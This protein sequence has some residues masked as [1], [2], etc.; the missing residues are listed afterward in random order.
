M[1]EVVLN[2]NGVAYGGWQALRVHRGLEE[3]SGAFEIVATELWP[4]QRDPREIR[5]GDRC[6]L[7][8]DG[9]TVITGFVD[10]VRPSYGDGRHEVLIRGRDA[11]GDLV[12]CSAVHKSGEWRNATL[13]QIAR[14][15]VAPFGLA[16]KVQT[17]VGAP[18]KQWAIQ[19]GESVFENLERAARHRGVLLLSDGQGALVIA[20][21]S[22]QRVGT[23]LERG[24]NI[25]SA[26][27]ENNQADRFSRYIVKGQRAG[28]DQDSGEVVA[29]QK[30]EAR[31]PGVGRYRPLVLVLEDQGD[32][33]TLQQRADFEAN[34]RAARAL[35][36]TA[37]VQGWSHA[38]GLWAPNQL[39]TV[40]DPWCRINRDLLVRAVDLVLD[41]QGTRAQLSLTIPDAYTL[42]PVPEPK[43][44]GEMI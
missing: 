26:S 19:E 27:A 7:Q 2:V 10:S 4:E 28:D 21:P 39:V 38:G 9:V 31:D 44:E 5:G 36:Y 33:A 15:L 6:A 40:R 3:V 12:D 18:F 32:G 29:S 1:A 37:S 43:D 20:R 35:D 11:T 34:V 23:A 16:V 41:E 22:K 8:I 14:D 30:A 25:L 42:L 13:T 17:D 24:M